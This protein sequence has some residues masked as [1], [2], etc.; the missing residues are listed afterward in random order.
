MPA[1]LY[2]SKKYCEYLSREGKKRGSLKFSSSFV[3]RYHDRTE[4]NDE[5]TKERSPETNS[6]SDRTFYQGPTACSIG[7]TN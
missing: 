7:Y 4:K 5:R 2:E 3:K 1:N 6:L